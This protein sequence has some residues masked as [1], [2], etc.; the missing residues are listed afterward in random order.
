MRAPGT[1]STDLVDTLRAANAAEYDHVIALRK[2]GGRQITLKFW[3]PEIVRRRRRLPV[4]IDRDGRHARADGL[5]QPGQE[6]L[7]SRKQRPASRLSEPQS[8]VV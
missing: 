7:R 2:L 1:P 8:G 5:P 4:R 6:W 3:I